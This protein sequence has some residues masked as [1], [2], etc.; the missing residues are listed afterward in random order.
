MALS[1]LGS[2][3]HRAGLRRWLGRG[4]PMLGL[5]LVAPQASALWDD[6]LELYASEAVT[7]DSNVFRLSKDQNPEAVIGR[8]SK[9]DLITTTTVGF[10]LNA[11]IS[12]QRVQLGA[13]FNRN[14]Y[15]R[16]GDLDNDGHDARAAWLWQA[17][18]S[19]NGQLGYTES[20]RLASFL[21]IQGTRP[22]S[23]TTKRTFGNAVYML[24]PRWELQGGLAEESRENGTA[25]FRNNDVDLSIADA[26][27]TYVAP[28]G[29]RIGLSL[30]QQDADFKNLQLTRNGVIDNNYLHR[31]V[32]VVT[33]WTITGKSHLN[34]RVDRVNRDFDQFGRSDYTG[35]MFRAAYDL[36]ATGKFTLGVVAQ[37][38]VNTVYDDATDFVLARG[39]TVLPSLDISDKLK[40][41]AAYD[42]S[43]REY[44]S[45]VFLTGRVDHVRISSANL[46][47]RPM[48]S[49]TL[50]LSGQHVKRSSNV[51]FEDTSANV[52][53]LNARIAF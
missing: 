13:A 16:F 39:F 22:N 36:K 20:K 21:D 8:S 37:R 41:S 42:Y 34:L 15:R 50:L 30:R 49:L 11:P 31:S 3:V 2:G 38:D 9:N 46:S 26:S 33:D 29:N 5:L 4:V 53:G 18:D 28:S 25:A 35:T 40:L 7:S 24:T 12:R 19:L 17:G 48:R 23:L 44:L 6:R 51:P 43:K 45:N 32:G 47:Y 1:H 10:N 52:I 14:H 27:L